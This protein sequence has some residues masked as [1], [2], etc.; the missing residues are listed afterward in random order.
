M[1]RKKKPCLSKRKGAEGKR[2]SERGQKNVPS[3]TLAEEESI[4]GLDTGQGLN[5]FRS[6]FKLVLF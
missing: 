5:Y 2:R 1:P 4:V 3:T 6:S